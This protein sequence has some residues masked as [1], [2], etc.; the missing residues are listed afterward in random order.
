M[1][2]CIGY[3]AEFNGKFT[4]KGLCYVLGAFK[5]FLGAMSG[6]ADPERLS[7]E[8]VRAHVR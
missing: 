4:L 5:A 8:Q 6:D 3:P 7:L 2:E 1:S